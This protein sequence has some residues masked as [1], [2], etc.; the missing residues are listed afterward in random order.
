MKILIKQAKIIDRLSPFNGK[1]KDLLI[2]GD[3]IKLIQD[4]ISADD[5]KVI[6][7]KNLHVSLGWADLKADFC[8]PGMEHK[9]TIESGLDAAAFGGFTHVGVVPSTSPVVDGKSQIQYMLRKAEHH[10]TSIHPI[11]TITAGMKGKD[12][13]EM[14]DMFLSGVRLFSDDLMHVN[15]GI[16]YRALLYAKNF[17]GR[18]ATFSRDISIAGNGMVNEGMASTKT[19]IKADPSISEIIEIERNIRLLEYTDG[20]L[21]LT[22]ISTGEGVDLIRKAKAKNFN[23][24]ADVHLANLIYTEES[25]FGFDTN[26]KVLP[27]L[28]FE[29]DR[30]ALW[31]GIKDNTIDCI[32]TDHRP[33]DK[34]EKEVEFDVA[35]FGTINLQTIFSSLCLAPEFDL[36]TVINAFTVNARDVLGI[37]STKIDVGEMADVTFFVPDE[38]WTFT[39]DD[40]CSNTDNSPLVNEELKGKVMGII[41]NGKSAIKE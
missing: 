7:A 30:T 5:A 11:G 31:E 14:Y 28:R 25:V 6:S 12:L 17:G 40:I 8:D 41:N 18:I 26:F 2:E 3:K 9:E 27:P 10:V 23:I 35:E 22:G 19:G 4:S 33:K 13:S 38:K 29:S 21:H 32:V 36:N 37:D 39:K 20:Y 34:E 24:T 15:S 16:M 1:S